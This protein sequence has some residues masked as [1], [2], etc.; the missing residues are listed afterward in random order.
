MSTRSMRVIERILAEDEARGENSPM[1]V[2][3]VGS[4]AQIMPNLRRGRRICSTNKYL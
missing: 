2:R 1:A 4:L 3:R